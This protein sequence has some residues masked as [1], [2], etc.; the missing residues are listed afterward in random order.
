VLIALTVLAFVAAATALWAL[1]WALSR[2]HGLRP[3]PNA[4]FN[5]AEGLQNETIVTAIV[6]A[7]NE[8]VN[9][10][11]CLRSLLAQ[12]C[13]RVHLKIVVVDDG[14]TDETKA[15]AE[16]I[17]LDH[18]PVSVIALEGPPP[19]W[20]GKPHACC[21]G[22]RGA[23]S[24][25]LWFVDADTFPSPA[26]LSSLLA[27]AGREHIDLVSLF[28]GQELRS[29]W[30]RLLMPP[31]GLLVAMAASANAAAVNDDAKHDAI[32]VGA[33]LL[34]HR[35]AY[36]AAGGHEA[37]KS[38]VI[39]DVALARAMKRAGHRIRLVDGSEFITVRMYRSFREI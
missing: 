3:L 14:S 20:M 33:C 9:V 38:E 8:A 21:T 28:P 35:E 36:E 11:R 4:V 12:R 34:V 2:L 16:R 25:W 7:R 39:E 32:A 29:F 18:A 5:P 1:A 17:A 23:K 6:P 31:A 15:I 37:V 13:D 22:A 27:Y 19:G 26:T 24:D 10:E 30:E